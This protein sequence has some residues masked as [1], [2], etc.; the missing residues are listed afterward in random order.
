MKNY[1]SDIFCFIFFNLLL[2]QT[3][4]FS[5]EWSEPEIIATN[6]NVKDFVT[7]VNENGHIHLLLSEDKTV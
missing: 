2:L 5:Q 6:R 4:L 7:V 1:I 3:L